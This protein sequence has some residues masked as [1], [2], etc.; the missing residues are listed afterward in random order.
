MA[1]KPTNPNALVHFI[2]ALQQRFVLKQKKYW[3]K[4]KNCVLYNCICVELN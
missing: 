2:T 1:E 3:Y 4:A